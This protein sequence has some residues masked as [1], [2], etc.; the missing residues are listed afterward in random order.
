MKARLFSLVLSIGTLLSCTQA[1]VENGT[2]LALEAKLADVLIQSGEPAQTILMAP[3]T[4]AEAAVLDDALENYKH[5]REKWDY[6]DEAT[7]G[8]FGLNLLTLEADY[9]LLRDSYHKVHGVVIAHWNDYD[10]YRQARL[11]SYD[12]QAR[13]IDTKVFELM[14]SQQQLETIKAVLEIGVLI[15]KA[16]AV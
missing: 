1:Q 4:E 8:E 13:S 14:K 6:A 11:T 16:A 9:L 15:A 10:T 3:L 5:F 2:R 12:N 7:G